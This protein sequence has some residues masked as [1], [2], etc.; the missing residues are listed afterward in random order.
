MTKSHRRRQTKK[1]IKRGGA[2]IM[3]S[4][5]FGKD[6]GSY[7]P[8]VNAS[9]NTA[10]GASVGISQGMPN[11]NLI[12]P[13]LAY[14][15]TDSKLQTGGRRRSNSN[16][17]NKSRKSRKSSKSRKSRSSSSSRR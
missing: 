12:G 2:I 10:Y 16:K 11:G 4:E 5:Y 3:P 15:P 8:T 14:G 1:F 6:S 13:N 9:Y 17:K 7:S